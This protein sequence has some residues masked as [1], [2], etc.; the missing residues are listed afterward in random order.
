VEIIA[1]DVLVIG[2]GAA[3]LSASVYAAESG[4]NVLVLDK[5][6]VSRSGSTVGSLQIAATGDW[7]SPE[8]S[9]DQ[10]EA[11]ILQSG[12]GLCEPEL[13][14]ILTHEI[15]DRMKDL[16]AWGLKPDRDDTGGYLISPTAGHRFPR[17]ISARNGQGGL[18]VLHTLLR[19]AKVYHKEGIQLWNDVI[20]TRLIQSDGRMIGAIALDLVKSE[21]YLIQARSVILAT[22]G[23]GQLY[24][25]TSNPVQVTG[26]GFSLA[27]RVGAK[28]IDM[29]QVQFYPVNLV[30]PDSLKGLCMSFHNIA[31]LRN[32]NEE[33]FMLDYD[34]ENLEAAT[35]DML[36]FAIASEIRAGRGTE[37]GGVWLDGRHSAQQIQN[38]FPYEYRLCRERGLDLSEDR[39]EVAPAAHFIMGG[40]KI[41]GNGASTVSGLYAAGETAGGVHGANR[42][43]NSSVAECLVY[44]ARVGRAAGS[45][46]TT[47]SSPQLH[48]SGAKQ[49]FNEE[50]ERFARLKVSNSNAFFRPSQVKEAV[51]KIMGESVGVIRTQSEL[52]AAHSAL[53]RWSERYE[54][55]MCIKDTLMT[56]SREYVDY[57]EVGNM[58]MTARAICVSAME[59]KESRG[60]HQRL[61]FS[62]QK[63]QAEHTVLTWGQKGMEVQREAVVRG[64]LG[65]DGR[66]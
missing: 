7:S 52:E 43:G 3:G 12:R 44:G 59:R 1:T 28:L 33:R 17:S 34:P 4:A 51:R 40:V 35:R 49:T 5:G 14:R 21:L 41:D 10:Y 66:A 6:I 56:L 57:I 29:E 27:L 53:I 54:H 48:L 20:T 11:D 15:H 32:A 2:S 37:R 16:I 50:K 36:A 60:A 47:D 58:L 26:D 13:V 9:P 24:P 19:R 64:G 39:A 31:E 46:A 61:D 63:A 65:V 38:W 25:M 45:F 8:D 42:L 62:K 30:T 23:M 18:A 55:E 22:G